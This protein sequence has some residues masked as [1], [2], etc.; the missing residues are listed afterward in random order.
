MKTHIKQLCIA[1]IITGVFCL[2]ISSLGNREKSEY[3]KIQDK[4][5]DAFEALYSENNGGFLFLKNTHLAHNEGKN[6]ITAYIKYNPTLKK[7]FL[8]LKVTCQ[9][10]AKRTKTITFGSN[11]GYEKLDYVNEVYRLT[12]IKNEG[13]KF[14]T[15]DIQ[16]G[17]LLKEQLLRMSQA[18][19]AS[20]VFTDHKGD[21]AFELTETEKQGLEQV[22]LAYKYIRCE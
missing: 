9:A 1:T 13:K 15:L 14:A 17:E 6:N 8:F 18:S 2:L 12:S 10:D 3:Q 11:A 22:I 4:K 5:K 16:I 21:H 20:I 7:S 19:S